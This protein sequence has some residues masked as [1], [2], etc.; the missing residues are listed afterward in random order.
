MARDPVCGMFVDER[1]S[2]LRSIY[3]GKAYHFCS[4]SCKTNFDRDPKKYT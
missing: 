3:M 4:A 2:K 1:T